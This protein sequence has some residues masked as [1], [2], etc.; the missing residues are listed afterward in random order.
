MVSDLLPSYTHIVKPSLRHTYLSFD[1]EGNLIIKSPEVS[2]A[3]IEQLLLKKAAWI[4]KSRKR[5]IQKKGK[6]PDFTARS[7]LYYKGIAYPLQIHPRL[8][9]GTSL[10]FENGI[11]F[12]YSS[13]QDTLHFQKHIDA[14]YRQEAER[15]LPGVVEHYSRKMQLFPEAI[16]FRKT[17]RQWGSC[18]GKNVLSLNTMLI[19]LPP[20]VIAYV[21]VHELAHIRHKHHQR[22]FWNL[23]KRY[24]PDY[25]LQIKELHTYT[26]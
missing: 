23:V 11:F 16:R 13:H 20:P 2:K 19:K 12:L 6:N 9:Q 5:V 3:Y 4:T 21:V 22:D 25:Q 8:K 17:K 18:S 24:M 10:S 15:Y 14:F 7:L 1:E 26:T